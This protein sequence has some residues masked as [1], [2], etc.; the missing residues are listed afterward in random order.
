MKRQWVALPVLLAASGSGAPA[1][2]ADGGLIAAAPALAPPV[3]GFTIAE[4][5]PYPS[6]AWTVLQ[7]VPSPEV[8]VGRAD[9]DKTRATFGLRWQLTPLVWS[10]GTNR[11]ISPW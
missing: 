8:A 9:H 10:W 11:R 5:R 3:A 6:L 4:V 1:Y 2:A 7:L